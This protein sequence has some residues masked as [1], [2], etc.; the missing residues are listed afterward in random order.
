MPSESNQ[1]IV[2]RE[3]DDMGEAKRKSRSRAEILA[4]EAR[5]IYCASTPTSVEHMPPRSMFSSKS[6]PS[7][8]E[9]ACC[10]ECNQGTGVAD[11]V[12]GFFARLSSDYK[13]D[14][15][16][17]KEAVHRK[18]T[19]ARLAPGFFEEFFRPEKHGPVL[20]RDELGIIKP[21][22][23]FRVDGPLAKAYLTVFAAKFGMAL[24]RE[25]VGQPLPL[26]GGV[27]TV[28]F[29]NAGLAQETGDA[30]LA[31]LPGFQT[32]QQGRFVVPA[33]FAYRY[34]CDGRSIVAALAGFHSNL[35]IFTVAASDPAFYNRLIRIPHSDF[36]RP[37]ELISR[38]S[39]ANGSTP[40]ERTRRETP[41]KFCS[42]MR[43]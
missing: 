11:L 15:A 17:V 12:A 38:I 21:F 33:Q 27:Y 34:N 35:H 39:F 19:L 41:S 5:C 32:L 31:K 26:T 18:G 13:A 6:R 23:Q 25:H 14:T 10:D 2:H 16:L 20:K 42:V 9:F 43:G 22:V 30:I 36:V 8:M 28:W 29:L 4:R 37:G 24:Y 1:A 40:S 3:L 7:G